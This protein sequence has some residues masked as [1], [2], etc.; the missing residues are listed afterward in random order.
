MMS[1]AQPARQPRGT[2]DARTYAELTKPVSLWQLRRQLSP[3]A[4]LCADAMRLYLR[5]GQLIKDAHADR[6][7]DRERRL[8]RA[9]RH[10]AQRVY[11]RHAQTRTPRPLPL[12]NLFA[13]VI[14][15][16]TAKPQ[17]SAPARPQPLSRAA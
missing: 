2:I 11:R 6:N 15:R 16:A 14:E 12:G 3:A 8:T 10:A 4:G 1:A 17:T 7:P 13:P 5:L 9:R